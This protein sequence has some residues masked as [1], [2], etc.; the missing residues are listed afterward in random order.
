MLG[1]GCRIRKIIMPL[2]RFVVYPHLEYHVVLV[3]PIPNRYFRVAGALK[4][5]KSKSDVWNG[6]CTRNS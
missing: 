6:S 4:K 3:S 5:G 1:K 2:N